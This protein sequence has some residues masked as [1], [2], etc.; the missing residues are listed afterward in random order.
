M[1][2]RTVPDPRAPVPGAWGRL[3]GAMVLA[4]MMFWPR[5]FILGLW[6]FGDLV[7]EA[8]AWPVAVLGFLLLP[9]TTFAYVVMWSVSSNVVSGAEWVVVG[10]AFI[11]DL[12]IWAGVRRLA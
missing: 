4:A 3:M 9:T 5:L 1:L 2:V 11:V 12:L 8:T 6:I 7:G 10:A